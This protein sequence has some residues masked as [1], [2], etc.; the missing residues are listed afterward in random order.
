MDHQ[1]GRRRRRPAP[2]TNG[3]PLPKRIRRRTLDNPCDLCE[4]MFSRKGLQCL[5]SVNGLRHH[6][7]ASCIASRDEGCKICKFIF[8]AVCKDNDRDWNENIHLVFRNS[9]Q[10]RPT[11]NPGIYGLQ[12]TFEGGLIDCMITIDT[13]A[14]EGLYSPNHR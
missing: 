9:L 13:F 6:T 14:R 12:C 2:E 11:N 4:L 3:Q 7:R 1:E 10:Q 5:S 8:L